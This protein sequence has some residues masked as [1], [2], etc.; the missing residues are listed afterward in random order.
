MI[1]YIQRTRDYYAAQG[2]AP[3][4][5]AHNEQTAFTPLSRP[6][7]ESQ[8]ALLTTAAPHR[9]EL[10]DQGPGAAY[11]AAAKFYEVYT[12]PTDPVPDLRISHIGYDRVHCKA[13]DPRTWLPVEALNQAAADGLIGA[14][15][16]QLIGIPTNRSQRTTLEQDAVAALAAV[17]A[18]QAD[19]ALLVPT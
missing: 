18:Q 7:A 2:Y 19:V 10:G 1:R 3:Y 6:L 13:E 9:S 16:E 17:K 14:L 11:N 5:W 15:C 4:H 12:L 8:L